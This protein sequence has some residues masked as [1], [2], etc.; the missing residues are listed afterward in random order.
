VRFVAAAAAAAAAAFKLLQLSFG[1][2]QTGS[3]HH[4]VIKAQPATDPSV[5]LHTR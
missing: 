1:C 3:R 4:F 2:T 5:S